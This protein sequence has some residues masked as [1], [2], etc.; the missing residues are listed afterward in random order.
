MSLNLYEIEKRYAKHYGL[1]I[2]FAI[3]KFNVSTIPPIRFIRIRCEV[4][5]CTIRTHANIKAQRKH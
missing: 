1:Y 5:L 3:L 4:R 2:N